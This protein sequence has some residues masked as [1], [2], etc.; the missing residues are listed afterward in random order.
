MNKI[1][2]KTYGTFKKYICIDLFVEYIETEHPDMSLE[3]AFDMAFGK[4]LPDN[5]T[6]VSLNMNYL[7]MLNSAMMRHNDFYIDTNRTVLKTYQ[8]SGIM[9]IVRED[10]SCIFKDYKRIGESQLLL[11]INNTLYTS[12]KITSDYNVNDKL[13]DLRDLFSLDDNVGF[14]EKVESLY[15]IFNKPANSKTSDMFADLQKTAYDLYQALSPEDDPTESVPKYCNF[16]LNEYIAY[17]ADKI[18]TPSKYILSFIN[19]IRDNKNKW[20]KGDVDEIRVM[21]YDEECHKPFVEEFIKEQII[22]YITI[23][24]LDQIFIKLIEIDATL[25]EIN[26]TRLC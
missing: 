23:R 25:Q 15:T 16:I 2:K 1:S 4:Y 19:F 17:L 21:L 14:Y 24:K 7:I 12:R 3:D 26:N 5:D 9:E 8:L 20:L 13:D 11:L 10:R 6:N 22:P 18:E